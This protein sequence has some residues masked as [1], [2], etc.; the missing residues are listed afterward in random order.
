MSPC[1]A[2]FAES[3]HAHPRHVAAWIATTGTPGR[4]PASLGGYFAPAATGL[5]RRGSHPPGSALQPTTSNGQP[6]DPHPLQTP[7]FAALYYERVDTT[8]QVDRLPGVDAPCLWKLREP[9]GWPMCPWIQ[10]EGTDMSDTTDFGK[11]PASRYV[12][13]SP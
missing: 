7:L 10:P 11:L 6:H 8:T 4:K 3:A 9:C 2:R 13:S 1:T 12:A 5:C